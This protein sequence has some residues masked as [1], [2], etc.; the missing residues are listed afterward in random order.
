MF[1]GLGHAAFWVT[2]VER[3]LDFYCNKIGLKKHFTLYHDDGSLWLTYI[4]VAHGEY[5]E[6]FPRDT[7]NQYADM[8]YKHI[9]ITVENAQEAYETIKARGVQLTEPKKGKCGSIQFWATDPDGNRIEFMELCP[10]GMQMMHE[11]Q[12]E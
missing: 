3:S 4:R 9:S 10:D 7:V 2:D 12:Y 11:K 5:I 1:K 8:S 6:I